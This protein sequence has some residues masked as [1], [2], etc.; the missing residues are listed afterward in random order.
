MPFSLDPTVYCIAVSNVLNNTSEGTRLWKGILWKV[1]VEPLFSRKGNEKV[2]V[3]LAPSGKAD[4]VKPG[5]K[6]A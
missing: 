4:H 3:K 6:Y 5:P 1:K 2:K